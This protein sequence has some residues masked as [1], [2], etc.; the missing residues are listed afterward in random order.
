MNKK[1]AYESC[2]LEIKDI[3]DDDVILTSGWGNLGG[4]DEP[5]SDANG[6]T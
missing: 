5:K 3:S 2:E 1:S 6:W 4:D